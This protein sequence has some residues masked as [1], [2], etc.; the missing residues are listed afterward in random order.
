MGPIKE[1]A[2]VKPAAYP[3]LYPSFFIAG[4]R[5]DER[6]EAS[7]AAEPLTPANIIPRQC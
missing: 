2:A 4:I 1:L 3:G 6:P 7:A 5:I